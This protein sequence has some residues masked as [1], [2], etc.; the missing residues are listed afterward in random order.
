MISYRRMS[1][2]L[3]ECLRVLYTIDQRMAD[4]TGGP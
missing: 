3:C 4:D 1:L 2:S